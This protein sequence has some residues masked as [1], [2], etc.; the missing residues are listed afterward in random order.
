MIAIGERRSPAFG[1]AFLGPEPGVAH[2]TRPGPHAGEDPERTRVRTTLG[3]APG[4]CPGGRA[5]DRGRGAVMCMLNEALPSRITGVELGVDLFE[6]GA[7][8]GLYRNR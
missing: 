4:A 8:C 3:W 2:A 5:A 7:I 6:K 1:D